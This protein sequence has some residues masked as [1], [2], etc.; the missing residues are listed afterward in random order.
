[1]YDFPNT[2]NIYRFNQDNNCYNQNQFEIE[3]NHSMLVPMVLCRVELKISFT[4]I[5]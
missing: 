4:Q 1:M 3:L 2:W 5:V